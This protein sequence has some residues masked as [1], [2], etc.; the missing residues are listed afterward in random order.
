MAPAEPDRK[1]AEL[2]TT[3]DTERLGYELKL[4]GCCSVHAGRV[5]LLTTRAIWRRR[6]C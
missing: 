5:L 3:A 6:R 1:I 4:G 2:E